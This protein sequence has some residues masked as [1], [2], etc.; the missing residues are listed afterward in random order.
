MANDTW[1]GK[2]IRANTDL[3]REYFGAMAVQAMCLPD[4]LTQGKRSGF[5]Y[6]AQGDIFLPFNQLS[7]LKMDLS[8]EWWLLSQEEKELR[9][10][11]KWVGEMA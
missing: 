7:L 10:Y 5:P 8:K 3:G 9:T 4:K 1:S 2:W 6:L 11:P